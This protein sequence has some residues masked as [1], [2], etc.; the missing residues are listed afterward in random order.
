[1][2]YWGLSFLHGVIIFVVNYFL[3][4]PEHIKRIFYF[5]LYS[6]DDLKYTL[7][8]PSFQSVKIPSP[9]KPDLDQEPSSEPRNV[10]DQSCDPQ[11]T[12]ADI[13]PPTFN[14]IYSKIQD[15]YR[16][17]NFPSILHDFPPNHY[18]YLPMFDGKNLTAEKHIHVFEHFTD[19]F[20]IEH[21]DVYIRD[22]S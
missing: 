17:L 6:K 20:E 3:S 15:K 18:K 14:P 22:F 4:F 1:M 21:N 13:I 12:K 8:N 5:L 19:L 16:S 2:T 7:E 9:C 11:E 10:Y